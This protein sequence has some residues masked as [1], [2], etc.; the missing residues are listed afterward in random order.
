[1]A[2]P[3]SRVVGVWLC[4]AHASSSG[5]WGHPIPLS[6]KKHSRP[7]LSQRHSLFPLLRVQQH[8][9]LNPNSKAVDLSSR[10]AVTWSESVSLCGLLF[11]RWTKNT[12]KEGAGAP[13]ERGEPRRLSAG[14]RKRVVRF[15]VN[16]GLQLISQWCYKG[17]RLKRGTFH[18]S[19]SSQSSPR[20]P[21]LET[22]LSPPSDSGF[23]CPPAHTQGWV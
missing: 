10:S 9:Q 1:M 19:P 4:A 12:R 7:F 11:S 23:G 20:R 17:F 16:A 14:D 21:Q 6:G 2:E 3:D 5:C 18:P 15:E 8:L 22:Q 13:R